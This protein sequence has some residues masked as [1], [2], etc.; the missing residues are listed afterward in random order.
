MAHIRRPLVA[1]AAVNTVVFVGEAWAGTR[2][3]SLSLLMDAVHTFS[4]ELALICL[5]LAYLV[6]ARASRR[7]QRSANLLN[8]FWLIAISAALVWQSVARLAHPRPVLGWLP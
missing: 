6:T 4:D 7:L 2:A 8:G 1:A 3:N 5:W